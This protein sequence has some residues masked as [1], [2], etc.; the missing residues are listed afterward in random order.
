MAKHREI[1]LTCEEQDKFFSKFTKA[2]DEE[3]WVWCGTTNAEGYGI[4]SFGRGNLI[5]SR[6]SYAI[7]NPGVN[8]DDFIIC[9][10]CDNPS[11]VNPNHLFHGTDLDNMRDAKRK[12]RTHRPNM[13]GE[14]NS[15]ATISEDDVRTIRMEY[16]RSCSSAMA[17][18]YG[19]SR[20][21]I[22]RIASGRLW[23]HVDGPPVV[24]LTKWKTS[25]EDVI[26]M[27]HMYAD[28]YSCAFIA[29][30]Y[31]MSEMCARQIVT[32]LSRKSVGG[33]IIKKGLNWRRNLK[34]S[35]S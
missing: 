30:K 2:G 22:A 16:S 28:G 11:C 10:R 14:L 4:I 32:G 33:P 8:I 19:L 24:K 9:H 5:A 17:D 1:K 23:G 6:V 3:C 29:S 15:R 26:A 21:T 18:R 7:Y 27:R 35:K 25:P 13:K 34:F 12:G 20:K 31:G